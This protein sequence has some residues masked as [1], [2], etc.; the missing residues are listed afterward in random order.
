MCGGGGW[1]DRGRVWWWR[2][3]GGFGE[4][5]RGGGGILGGGLGGRETG[6]EDLWAGIGVVCWEEELPCWETAAIDTPS[7]A[8]V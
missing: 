8:D 3:R 6:V 7:D 1:R 4:G 2:D 5:W